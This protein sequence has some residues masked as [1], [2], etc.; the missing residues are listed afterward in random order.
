VHKVPEF[1]LQFSQQYTIGHLI[2]CS[3]I[4]AIKTHFKFYPAIYDYAFQISSL[5]VFWW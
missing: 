4:Y 3:Q 5:T 2:T 1:S